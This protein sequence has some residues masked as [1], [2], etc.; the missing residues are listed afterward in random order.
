MPRPLPIK[1]VPA[2][3]M[4]VNRHIYCMFSIMRTSMDIPDHLLALARERAEHEHGTLR[5]VVTE[6]LGRFLLAGPI[7]PAVPT[8][9]HLPVPSGRGGLC[10]AIDPTDSSRLL[11]DA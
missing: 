11:E 4:L 8:P 1:A 6:A 2:L 7:S 9:F 3:I 5:D 10:A